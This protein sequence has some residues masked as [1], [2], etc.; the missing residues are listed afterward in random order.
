M[1]LAVILT[2]NFH[3]MQ[4]LSLGPVSERFD[5][6]QT[7]PEF[8]GTAVK[9]AELWRSIAARA[10]VPAELV[11][12]V[13]ALGGQ[14][15]ILVLNEDWCGDSVN[16]LPLFAK[17]AELAPNLELRILGRDANPDLMESHLTNGSRSIPVVMVLDE[18]FREYGW[19]GPRPAELQAWVLDTGKT[20]EKEDRYREVRRWYARDR[21]ATI[22]AE[23]VE[24]LE[25]AAASSNSD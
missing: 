18:N 10:S 21:G 11:E 7:F 1:P 22:L 16:S 24:L 25:R 8:L 19:W 17:L 23:F 2:A 12:R 4:T 15:K 6:A 14:W 20:M 13:T 9:N 3:G 5:R